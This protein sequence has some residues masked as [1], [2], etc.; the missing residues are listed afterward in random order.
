MGPKEEVGHLD[1]ADFYVLWWCRLPRYVEKSVV[2]I[3]H[4]LQGER[5]ALLS[6]LDIHQQVELNTRLFECVL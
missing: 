4:L 1:G 2:I 5:K 6:K 3:N